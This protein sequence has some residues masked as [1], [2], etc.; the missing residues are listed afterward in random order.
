MA[1]R[2]PRV[3]ALESGYLCLNHG[4]ISSQVHVLMQGTEL[5]GAS[6]SLSVKLGQ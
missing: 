4:S 3:G 6:I 1:Y 2:E 5:L